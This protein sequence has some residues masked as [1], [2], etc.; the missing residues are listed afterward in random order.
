[1]DYISKKNLIIKNIEYKNLIDIEQDVILILTNFYVDC[2]DKYKECI[3]AIKEYIINEGNEM[4][5]ISN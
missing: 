1:M 3:K 5:V 2:Q 4:E